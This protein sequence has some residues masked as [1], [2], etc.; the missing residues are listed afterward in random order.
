MERIFLCCV[1]I[2]HRRFGWF[3]MIG[4]GVLVATHLAAQTAV[5]RTFGAI[6]DVAT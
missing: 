6:D 3:L 4:E 2:P 5:L 1:K